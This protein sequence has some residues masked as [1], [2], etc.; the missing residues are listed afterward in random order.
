MEFALT[1]CAI[2][3]KLRVILFSK[4]FNAITSIHIEQNSGIYMFR[5]YRII[6]YICMC[7][8]RKFEEVCII[9]L[10]FRKHILP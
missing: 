2:I 1:D 3:Y 8:Y 6:L 9:I 7:V 4:L 5:E 10:E